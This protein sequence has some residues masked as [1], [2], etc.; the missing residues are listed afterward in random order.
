MALVWGSLV[1]GLGVLCGGAPGGVCA[2]WG[3]LG[4]VMYSN[5]T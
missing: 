5:I 4:A 1:P 3:G 2:G